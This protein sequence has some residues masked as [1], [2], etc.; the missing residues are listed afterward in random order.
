[1]RIQRSRMMT[2]C[3]QNM[4]KAAIAAGMIGIK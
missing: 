2:A 4:M 3:S 1:M